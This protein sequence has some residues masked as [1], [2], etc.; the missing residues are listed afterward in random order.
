MMVGTRAASR[1]TLT[2]GNVPGG[3]VDPGGRSAGPSP[4]AQVPTQGGL[5]AA[6]VQGPGTQPLLNTGSPGGDASRRAAAGTAPGSV[7]RPR[8][9]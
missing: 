9:V 4:W 7:D 5:L 8:F 2:R 3:I 6:G 1:G